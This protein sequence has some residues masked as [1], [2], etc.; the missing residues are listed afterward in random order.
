MVS[1]VSLCHPFHGSR[2]G[3]ATTDK[4]SGLFMASTST[5]SSHILSRFGGRRGSRPASRKINSAQVR[6]RFG[7]APSLTAAR[8][9]AAARR[10]AGRARPRRSGSRRGALNSSGTFPS[11]SPRTV[12]Q[13]DHPDDLVELSTTSAWWLRRSRRKPS[14][15]SAAMVSGARRIRRPTSERP[16]AASVEKVRDRRPSYAGCPRRRRGCRET[17]GAG[18]RGCWRRRAARRESGSSARSRRAAREAPSTGERHAIPGA[19][20]GAGGPAPA[21]RAPAVPAFGDRAARSFR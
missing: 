1:R 4:A 21:V 17:P 20:R 6:A 9:R 3:G 18:C 12:F 19:R 7:Q 15:R 5:G 2:A 14:S 13:R 16:A 10:A 8:A 11:S